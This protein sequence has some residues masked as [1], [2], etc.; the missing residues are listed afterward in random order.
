VLVS[1]AC[2]DISGWRRTIRRAG[3]AA[4]THAGACAP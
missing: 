4:V 2:L 1:L 3:S